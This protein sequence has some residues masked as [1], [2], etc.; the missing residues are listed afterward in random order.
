MEHLD[1]SKKIIELRK[2]QGLSQEELAHRCKMNVRSIQRIESGQV[3][4]R[5]Y[6]LRMLSEILEVRFQDRAVTETKFNWKNFSASVR[7]KLSHFI[8]QLGGPNMHEKNILQ[9]LCR[10]QKDRQI[11]GICGGLG[12]YTSIPSWFWRIL[13]IF[14]IFFYGSGAILYLLFWIFMPRS[15]EAS[16]AAS[17]VHDTWLQ[18]FKKST[19]D[20]KLAGICGGLGA[21]TPVP[22]WCWRI[23]FVFSLLFYGLGGLLYLLLWIFTPKAQ[24]KSQDL[25]LACTP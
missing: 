17:P 1:L 11:A 14:F 16:A 12:T 3:K 18:Q 19:T 7:L 21:T 6:T 15:T 10:S 8:T 22:S 20:K 24:D 13:F 25:S 23:C 4:P 5:L 2:Q 9:H